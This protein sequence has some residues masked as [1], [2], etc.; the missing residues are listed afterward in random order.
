MFPRIPDSTTGLVLRPSQDEQDQFKVS[1][2]ISLQ[3]VPSLTVQLTASPVASLDQFSIREL[4]ARAPDSVG[5]AGPAFPP[6][7]PTRRLGLLSQLPLLP[8]ASLW[9]GGSMAGGIQTSQAPNSA[10]EDPGG[11]SLVAVC[12]ETRAAT[13]SGRQ[14]DLGRLHSCTGVRPAPRA[15]GGSGMQNETLTPSLRDATGGMRIGMVRA[16]HQEGLPIHV[17]ARNKCQD[18]GYYSLYAVERK[19]SRIIMRYSCLRES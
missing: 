12:C 13:G 18:Y 8:R 15:L 14:M 5:E 4:L 7:S 19:Q 2:S 10:P 1:I 11:S 6:R 17:T 16:H 9:G 3:V